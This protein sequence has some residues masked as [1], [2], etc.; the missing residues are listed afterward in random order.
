[1]KNLKIGWKIFIVMA[2]L[3]ITSVII[4][5]VGIRQLYVI[6]EKLTELAERTGPKVDMAAKI[7]F[8]LMQEIRFGKNA[9]LTEDDS[10]SREYAT[11]AL[12]QFHVIDE[13]TKKLSAMLDDSDLDARRL[14]EEF[15]ERWKKLQE[16][17]ERMLTLAMTNSNVKARTSAEGK[18]SLALDT[19]T[20]AIDHMVAEIQSKIDGIKP[21]AE[22]F[23]ETA[24]QY[25]SLAAQLERLSSMNAAVLIIQRDVLLH[26]TASDEVKM[27]EIESRTQELMR[28]IN[29]SLSQIEGKISPADRSLF[30][31]ARGAYAAFEKVT[32]D[33]ISLSRQNTNILSTRIS[34]SEGK[35]LQDKCVALLADLSD[36][37]RNQLTVDKEEGYDSFVRAYWIILGVSVV[38]VTVGLVLALIV[39]R[40][41]TGPIH[42]A[43]MLADAVTHGDLT[44]RLGNK[45]KDEIGKL[46]TALDTVTES[47]MEIVLGIRNTSQTITSSA[48]EMASTSEQVLTLSAMT[49]GKAQ[50]VAGATEQMTANV[51]SMAGAAEEMSVNISS[52][53]AAT[54]ELSVNVGTISSAAEQTSRNVHNVANSVQDMSGSIKE[55]ADQARDGSQIANKAADL[56][57][58]TTNTMSELNV[59]ATEISKV[60]EMIKTIALQTNL[61]ALNA[62]IE[63]S[64]AG[65]AGKGFAVVANEI[66]ELAN[67]SARAAEDIA[68]KIADV[69]ESTSDAVNAIGK[70][71]EV[72]ETMNASSVRITESVEKQNRSAGIISDNV[73]EASRGVEHIARSIAEVAKGAVDMSRNVGQAAAGARDMS[74]SAGE[75]AKVTQEIAANIQGFSCATKENTTSAERVNQTARTLTNLAVELEKSV[76]RFKVS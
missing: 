6:S 9:I 12:N 43:V 36:Q 7:R 41:I 15:S 44:V 2:L 68:G 42:R 8:E 70:V 45:C 31:E 35:P 58:R 11:M 60:T 74:Q 18:Q 23:E 17:D 4:A 55:I 71:A 48:S 52:I 33:I 75:S 21:D 30:T 34:L 29:E 53:S 46:S 3:V 76:N 37:L 65:E 40:Q 47:L 24:E 59:A 67:Q 66:K 26:V 61:L 22:N 13:T 73:S 56:A 50:T 64:S 38:G 20:R 16:I 69:Q 63:A 49:M 5:G 39:S 14:L 62:T 19:F 28:Q 57:T 51:N 54:E 32:K 25:R 27:D 1:M 72:I 10:Q